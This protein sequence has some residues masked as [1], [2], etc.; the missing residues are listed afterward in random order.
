MKLNNFNNFNLLLKANDLFIYFIKSFDVIIIINYFKNKINFIYN[1]LV[2]VF[3][4]DYIYYIKRFRI[5]YNMSS[6]FSKNNVFFNESLKILDRFLSL[7]K[8]FKSSVWIEREI[9]DMFGI[10]FF[11]NWDLRKILTDYTFFGFP[12]RKDFPLSGFVELY[13]DIRKKLTFEVLIELMQEFRFY[14]VTS[15]I[16]Y[17]NEESVSI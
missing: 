4:C 6:F 16:E 17:W 11:N 15:L 1:Y 3:V 7:F 10:I 12:L 9:Y 5:V 8:I 14:I 2:D 13:Y